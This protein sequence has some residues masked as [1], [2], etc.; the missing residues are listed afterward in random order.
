MSLCVL[1]S[2]KLSKS[3]FHKTAGKTRKLTIKDVATEA[4]VSFKTVSRVFNGEGAVREETRLKVER[5]ARSLGFT[6]SVVARQFIRGHADS[7]GIIVL[8]LPRWSYYSDVIIGVQR[9]CQRH[10]Y[11]VS[12]YPISASGGKGFFALGRAI[13]SGALAGL[14][15][16]P[17]WSSDSTLMN[18]LRSFDTRLACLLTDTETSSIPAVFNRDFDGARRLCQ[19][20]LS[21]GHENIVFAAGS[22]SFAS[23][24]ARVKGFDRAIADANL[25]NHTV[26]RRFSRL[27]Y[28]SG[29]RIADDLLDRNPRPTAIL[30][31]NDFLAAGILYRFSERGLKVPD[32]VSIAG[33]GDLQIASQVWPGLTTMRQD[34]EEMAAA[35]AR[36]VISQV[37]GVDED[38][39]HVFFDNQLIIRGSTASPA[40]V[41][42]GQSSAAPVF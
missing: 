3:E 41:S 27:N 28:Q 42:S 26:F 25:A 32:D 7:I 2:T 33:F 34:T 10:G 40:S 6:P 24:K 9:E 21:Q 11:T 22:M 30:A 38:L 1:K 23:S 15:V 17:P 8:D 5:A 29:Y 19:H 36:L 35:A 39:E 18:K 14:V 20:L 13:S 37:E 4:G 31:V 16:A 12:V